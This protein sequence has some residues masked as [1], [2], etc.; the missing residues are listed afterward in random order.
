MN[1]VLLSI[2]QSWRILVCLFLIFIGIHI[3]VFST[4][5][6]SVNLNSLEE[7]GY[8]LKIIEEGQVPISKKM[9]VI[10]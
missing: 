9:M 3:T 4:G 10:R 8:L 7:G 5:T 6:N 2:Q 1:N